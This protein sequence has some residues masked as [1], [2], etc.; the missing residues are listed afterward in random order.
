MPKLKS[1]T[2]SF[3]LHSGSDPIPFT[4]IDLAFVNGDPLKSTFINPKPKNESLF[5]LPVLGSNPREKALKMYA[6]TPG[7]TPRPYPRE[8]KQYSTPPPLS[9]GANT[10][11]TPRGKTKN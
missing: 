10:P 3:L 11:R 1:T 6:Y 7:L 8:L 9:R 4:I 2:Y 5:R